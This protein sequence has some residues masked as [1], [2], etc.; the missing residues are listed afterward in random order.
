MHCP[1]RHADLCTTIVPLKHGG[2]CR[3]GRPL[4]SSSGA[5]EQGDKIWGAPE[6]KVICLFTNIALKV[7]YYV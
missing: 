6:T 5:T 4:G 2:E 1:V 7:N 3:Q